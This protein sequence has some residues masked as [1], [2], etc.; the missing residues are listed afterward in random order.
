MKRL[1]L[2]FPLFL[3]GCQQT[4]NNEEARQVWGAP[5]EAPSGGSSTKDKDGE[6]PQ[7]HIAAD[8]PR[9][10]SAIA[11]CER[12]YPGGAEPRIVNP[13]YAQV[14]KPSYEV[15]CYRAF[16]VGH[17]GRTRTALWSAEVLDP[18]SM[19]LASRLPRDSSFRPDPNL[20]E[21]HR[22][23]LDDYRGSGWERGHLAP[24]ADMPTDEAQ[25]ESFYLSNIVPQNGPM[26]GGAWRELEMNVRN[27]AKKRRVYI[28]TG[29]IFHNATQTLDGRVLVPT[30]MYKAMFA[31]NKGAVVFI[32]SNNK[33]AT[34][35]TLTVDEFTRLYGIDPFPGVNATVRKHNIALGPIPAEAAAKGDSGGKA[36]G[37]KYQVCGS[38]AKRLS[39]NTWYS[40]EEFERVY[41]RKPYTDEID[42][43]G[44]PESSK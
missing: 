28:V 22:S 34:G 27:E 18:N 20:P 17:S 12:M 10:G 8:P 44:C 43:T 33:Q 31:V 39:H 32:V 6:A 41:G 38:R 5:A 42:K 36:Q 14:I 23:E 30:A 15:L 11:G 13:E 2:A 7:V 19:A 35:Y 21:E 25:E 29:P 3:A 16:A 4:N 40:M 26:N 9:K 24:S 37:E 1:F